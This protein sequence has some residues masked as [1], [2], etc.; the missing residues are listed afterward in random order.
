M[1]KITFYTVCVFFM[2]ALLCRGASTQAGV[3]TLPDETVDKDTQEIELILVTSPTSFLLYEDAELQDLSDGISAE[4]TSAYTSLAQ[5]PEGKTYEVVLFLSDAI[6]DALGATDISTLKSQARQ[7]VFMGTLGDSAHLMSVLDIYDS[8][9]FTSVE[10]TESVLFLTH[11]VPDGKRE[12]V[13]I[14]LEGLSLKQIMD[15]MISWI[16]TV[17]KEVAQK[18]VQSAPDSGA[19]NAQYTHE[20]K[21]NMDGGS[22]RFLVNAYQLDTDRTDYNWFLFTTSIQSAIDDYKKDTGRC[23]W[24]TNEMELKAKVQ[25]SSGA[26]LYDYMPTG[27]VGSTSTGFSI[28]GTLTT[29]QAGLTGGYSQ[30]YVAPDASIIDESNYSNN[31]AEWK[32]SF[33][34]PDY[35]WYPLYSGPASVAQHSYETAP[36]FI[37]QVPKAQCAVVSLSPKIYHEK[38]SLTYYFLVL[39]VK[40]SGEYWTD[41]TIQMTVCPK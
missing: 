9:T 24:F 30:S 10:G 19:W 35:T 15:A 8:T 22:Y 4:A 2:A 34:G 33:N 6:L 20:W 31:T 11:G 36:A 17:H 26:S 32:V 23:G 29:S 12:D 27:T 21:G 25:S 14:S 18:A 16:G 5:I 41:S 13:F 3:V 39:S 38:D 1:S 40:K 7:G 28:G 37:A